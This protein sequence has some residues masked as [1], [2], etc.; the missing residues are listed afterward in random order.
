MY[1]SRANTGAIADAVN[2]IDHADGIKVCTEDERRQK[3]RRFLVT[4]DLQLASQKTPHRRDRRRIR[5]RLLF[6]SRVD[7]ETS[8]Q[9]ANFLAF[10][11]ARCRCRKYAMG[12][13]SASAVTSSGAPPTSRCHR[14]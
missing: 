1:H 7:V 13:A 14:R 3:R 9:R 12:W 2:I 8:R 10:L 6:D 4:A 11:F 5:S